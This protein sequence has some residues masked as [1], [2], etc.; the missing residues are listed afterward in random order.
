[1]NQLQQTTIKSLKTHSK[2][3]LKQVRARNGKGI[4]LFDDEDRE[5]EG[6][7]VFSA[8]FANPEQLNFASIHARG[9]LCVSLTESRAKVLGLKLQNQ[10]AQHVS[11]AFTISVDASKGITSGVSSFDKHKTIQVL[12]NPKSKCTDL[13]SPGH[14]FPLIAKEGGLHQRRGHT[15]GSATLMTLSGLKP[16]A[17]ICEILNQDG[18]MARMKECQTLSHKWKM[19]FVTIDEVS[20][21]Q[22]FS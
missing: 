18:T 16:V 8:E 12:T 10:N 17:V 14:I 6:D 1:M 22:K 7:I 13:K 15:E 5:N 21:Y 3:I 9:T 20:E 11:P 4:V 2:N 19:P